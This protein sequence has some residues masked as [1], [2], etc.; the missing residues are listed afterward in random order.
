[1]NIFAYCRVSSKAQDFATQRSAI[2]RAATARGDTITSW[3]SEKRS[4]RLLARPELDR[5]RADAR[6][7]FIRKLY[8]YR[9]DR[10]TRS[11]IADTLQVVEELRRH[12]CEVVSV[13]DGFDLTGPAAEIILAVVSWAAKMERLAINER[14]AAA[15]E[16]VEAEGGKW[17]RPS[18]FNDE[19]RAK[20]LAMHREG[21]SIRDIAIA[22]KVPKS[23]VARALK[24]AT[25]EA[26]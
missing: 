2:E 8:V 16:R 4:G 15:R 14:I 6:A 26:A 10:L 21:R 20:V 1:M 22:V 25:Q 17:G 5:L 9:L 23:T 24:A 7:G 11:G 12:G 13:A 3:R 19:D 18:R